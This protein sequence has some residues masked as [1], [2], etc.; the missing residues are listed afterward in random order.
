[1]PGKKRA[2]SVDQ[3]EDR[4]GARLYV[5][6]PEAANGS[7]GQECPAG[8]QVFVSGL[9]AADG[10]CFIIVNVKNGV[11]LGNLQLVMDFLGQVEQ[12]QL[13]SLA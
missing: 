4:P 9:E 1:M 8:P 5:R 2:P 12:L 10:P 7:V 3:P 6:F 11:K 13:S